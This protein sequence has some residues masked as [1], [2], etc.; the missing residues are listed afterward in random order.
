MHGEAPRDQLLRRFRNHGNA[1]LVGTSSFWEGVD[2]PGRALHALLL[3]RIPFRVPTEPVTAAQCEAIE[4]AGG[5]S[6]LEY[7]IPHAALR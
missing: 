3:A 5:D 6:F 7:M 1:V 4:K 2:V